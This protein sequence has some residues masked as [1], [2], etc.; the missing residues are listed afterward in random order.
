LYRVVEL[1]IELLRLR[2]RTEDIPA[3]VRKMIVDP[4]IP[5]NRITNDSL[6]RLM[7]RLHRPGTSASSS[8]VI[9]VATLAFGKDGPMTSA[10][11]P[12]ADVP[13][14]QR[15]DPDAPHLPGREARGAQAL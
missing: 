3:L 4:A 11:A 9:A 15:V 5:R 13:G 6:E 2:E 8:N 1:R 7:R 10:S 12:R 14:R